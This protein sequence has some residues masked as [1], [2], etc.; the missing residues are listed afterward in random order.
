MDDDAI[1][2][3]LLT[4]NPTAWLEFTNKYSQLLVAYLLRDK[5]FYFLSEADAIIIV[6]Q[7]LEKLVETP[8]LVDPSRGTLQALAYTMARN[9]AR[10]LYRSRAQSSAISIQEYELDLPDND[11]A[12]D[13]VRS[14]EECFSVE[15]LREVKEIAAELTESEILHLDL[16]K[17]IPDLKGCEIADKLG[18]SEGAERT[19]WHRL[20]T[21]LLRKAK[22]RPYIAAELR[23]SE[24]ER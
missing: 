14:V 2:K 17:R 18:I 5:E 12:D 11:P 16:R 3:G 21:K 22:S 13:S 1:L 7:V 10:D 6:D 15:V 9:K 24:Q 8:E 4:G 19:R 23:K 20:R